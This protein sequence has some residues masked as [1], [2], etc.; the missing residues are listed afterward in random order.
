[1]REWCMSV[2]DWHPD[3]DIILTTPSVATVI[4]CR[5]SSDPDLEKAAILPD[6]AGPS[7]IWESV[8]V[9]ADGL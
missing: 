5:D 7:P 3:L 4:G 2:V 9:S 6:P 8:C 1:M